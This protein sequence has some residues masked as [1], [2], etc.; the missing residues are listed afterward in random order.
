MFPNSHDALPLPTQPNLEQYKKLAKDLVK[1]ADANPSALPAWTTRWLRT[2]TRLAHFENTDQLQLNVDQWSQQFEKFIDAQKS[3]GKLPL[4]KA[5]FAL[6]RAH[7]FESWPKFSQH[8]DALARSNS[9]ESNFEV[10]TEAVIDG[11]LETLSRLLKKNPDLARARSTRQHR[12]MLLHFVA[13][14]GVESYRQKSPK[15]AAKIAELLLDSDADPNAEADVYGA[16]ATTLELV[17]T[18]IHPERAGVQEPLM[19]LLLDRGASK[20]AASARSRN[21]ISACLANGR[22]RAADFLAL[23]GFPIDLEAASGLGR[24][25]IVKTFFDE[26]GKLLGNATGDQLQCGFLWA[27]EYGRNDVVRFLLERGVSVHAQAGGQTALHWAVIGAHPE[28]IKLL[29]E[30]GADL[31]AKNSYDGTPLGQALWSALHSDGQFD[32]FPVIE[33]LLAAGAK[34]SVAA[35]ESIEKQSSVPPETRRRILELLRTQRET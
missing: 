30:H 10:A 26:S 7:G 29:L 6:A 32:Y 4:A 22:P 1:A 21:V 27:C 15:N 3:G 16:G 2:L 20:E 25:D 13:A 5:Q 35:R 9:S 14:N 24:L 8:L 31:E 18:S 34:A 11:D 23:H 19:Q 12:A 17:A 28:T 33:A